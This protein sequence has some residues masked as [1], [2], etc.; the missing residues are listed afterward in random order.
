MRSHELSARTGRK[1]QTKYWSIVGPSLPRIAAAPLRQRRSVN[2]LPQGSMVGATSPRQ[3]GPGQAVLRSTRVKVV[4]VLRNSSLN[5]TLYVF[6]EL[7][8]SG[9]QIAQFIFEVRSPLGHG[10]LRQV[11]V[12]CKTPSKRLPPMTCEK[13]SSTCSHI[14]I[15]DPLGQSKMTSMHPDMKIDRPCCHKSCE[16]K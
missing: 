1:G 13:K 10:I 15:H 7:P 16:P 5:R 8:A 11:H 3:S 12:L 14:V 9:H 4:A 2:G 6:G